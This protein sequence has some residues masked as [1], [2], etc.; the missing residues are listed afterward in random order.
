MS[1]TALPFLFASFLLSVAADPA[2]PKETG[3][4]C[5]TDEVPWNGGCFHRYEWRTDPK[6]CP[7]G[8]ILIPDG[9]RL[10]RCTPCDYDKVTG[11]QPMNYCAGVR[12]FAADRE[13]DRAFG[14]LLKQ[15]PEQA[16]DLEKAWVKW[17]DVECEA[18]RNRYAGGLDGAPR[19]RRVQAREDARPHRA[20]RP[21]PQ[22]LDDQVE[23]GAKQGSRFT[24]L[25]EAS[26]PAG[27]SCAPPRGP[28]LHRH[29][30]GERTRSPARSPCERR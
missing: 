21:P 5:S 10:P 11:Q 28:R 14:A 4:A 9:E 27:G 2:A 24:T 1:V 8:V 7:D 20:T 25:Y 17:R 16:R 30:P 19:L 18:E 26:S 3:T 13:L 15:Y 12:F 23:R 22:A 6:S 29:S